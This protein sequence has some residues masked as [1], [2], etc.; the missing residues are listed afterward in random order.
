MSR[1]IVRKKCTLC[2]KVRRT[3]QKEEEPYTCRECE[4]KVTRN[5]MKVRSGAVEHTSDDWVTM[6]DSCKFGTKYIKKPWWLFWR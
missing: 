3:T 2:G 6:L 5:Y 4:S 1:K